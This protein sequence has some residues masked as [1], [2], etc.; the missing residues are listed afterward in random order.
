MS[1]QNAPLPEFYNCALKR[2]QEKELH[3]TRIAEH[4]ILILMFD[5]ILRFRE[6]GVDQE[7][8][9]G[10]YY[11]QRAGLFQQ[12]VAPCELPVY[13][14]VHFTCPIGED[15][16][17]LPLRGEFQPK[18][19]RPMTERMESLSLDRNADRFRLN[20]QMLRIF[21]ELMSGT[22]RHDETSHVAYR[23]K[24]YLDTKYTEPVRLSQLSH[25]FGY[26]EDYLIRLFKSH[27]G[28][29]PHRYLIGRRM[30]HARWLLE[31]TVLSTE[32][33][34]SAVGYPDFSAFYRAFCNV[35]GAAPGTF[36]KR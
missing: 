23:L 15:L 29:T 26:T 10:E 36:R 4:N 21:S 31:N 34:A 14:Y 5:G 3:V 13:F 33:I 35:H 12:G 32:Q 27:Y 7:L 9:A 22:P 1:L 25:S 2:F 24:T 8:R 11:V 18:I 6:D 17:G 28:V 16:A 20:S 30:D 19:L